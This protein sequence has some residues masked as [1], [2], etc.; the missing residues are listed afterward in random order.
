M[1]YVYFFQLRSPPSW[2]ARD[3]WESLKAVETELTS[4]AEP[5]ADKVLNDNEDAPTAQPTDGTPKSRISGLTDSI[6]LNE[7]H[8]WMQ[9]LTSDDINILIV[10]LV[11][12][13]YLT[14]LRALPLP[15][16]WET[17]LTPFQKLI[18]IKCLRPDALP[19]AVT[20]FIGK[21]LG[22][23]L[24]D[25]IPHELERAFQSTSPTVPL[26]FVLSHGADPTSYL[27]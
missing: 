3:D 1:H 17:C 20:Q 8:M 13:C 12:K 25:I 23:D 11:V 16:S 22:Q 27:D 5:V 6:S 9:Y 10:L 26:L 19:Q 21:T 15:G 4:V 24:L 18:V 2:I 7:D 14:I